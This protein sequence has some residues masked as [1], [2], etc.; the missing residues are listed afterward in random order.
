MS[1]LWCNKCAVAILAQVICKMAQIKERDHHW[2]DGF[3]VH[4]LLAQVSIPADVFRRMSISPS[5]SPRLNSTSNGF[6]PLN[7]LAYYCCHHPHPHLLLSTRRLPV[8]SRMSCHQSALRCS[9]CGL[10]LNVN[11]QFQVQTCYPIASS[12]IMA[13][14]EQ[15]MKKQEDSQI[16][17]MEW[18]KTTDTQG[19][20][21]SQIVYS[22]SVN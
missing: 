3:E 2:E 18:M 5:Q 16:K 15:E 7:W 4:L 1:Q 17:V 10:S 22:P 14:K 12:L 20:A 9:A 13:A 19:D 11:A 8:L 21:T 6:P